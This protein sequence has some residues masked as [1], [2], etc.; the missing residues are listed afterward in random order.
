MPALAV[1]KGFHH[2][3]S[4]VATWAAVAIVAEERLRRV[5]GQGGVKGAIARSRIAAS[6]WL[7][8]LYK[9]KGRVWMLV[10]VLGLFSRVDRYGIRGATRR[11]VLIAC[12]C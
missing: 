9:V 2:S 10:A 1:G 5:A 3:R 4:E 11:L 7:V 8:R 12:S 6:C